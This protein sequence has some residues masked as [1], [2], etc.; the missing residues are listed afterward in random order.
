MPIV[1]V[2]HD[3]TH[4]L[5]SALLDPGCHIELYKEFNTGYD[6]KALVYK[7]DSS[8][9]HLLPWI[10]SRVQLAEIQAILPPAIRLQNGRNLPERV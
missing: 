8:P 10:H 4:R 1:G 3:D 7:P 5:L 9:K 2:I 6:S